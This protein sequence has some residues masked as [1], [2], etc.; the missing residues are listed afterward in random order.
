MNRPPAARTC[1]P[2]E[3]GV[4]KIAEEPL[5]KEAR[6]AK[7][8]RLIK[9]CA[10]RRAKDWTSAK[11]E[12]VVSRHAKAAIQG[13]AITMERDR[14]PRP[15]GRACAEKAWWRQ[16]CPPKGRRREPSRRVLPASGVELSHR[17]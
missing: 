16:P 7:H 14:L 6:I 3:V 12:Q 8:H 5:I 4:L 2:R 10:R 11:P 1:P 15:P 9:C 13:E 17:C